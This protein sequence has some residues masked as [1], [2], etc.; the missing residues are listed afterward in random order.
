MRGYDVALAYT[1]IRTF[2]FVSGCIGL[3]TST[4]LGPGLNSPEEEVTRPEGHRNIGSGDKVPPSESE[5]NR[6]RNHILLSAIHSLNFWGTFATRLPG[7]W[8]LAILQV[9]TQTFI[10]VLFSIA[11]CLS[12]NCS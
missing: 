6:I 11:L 9:P 1:C 12:V 7:N 5:L 3:G 2:L 4:Q 10:N 8:R